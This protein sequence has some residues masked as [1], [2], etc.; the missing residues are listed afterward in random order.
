MKYALSPGPSLPDPSMYLAYGGPQCLVSSPFVGCSI[1][2]TSALICM[3][4]RP[5]DGAGKINAPEISKY[6][7]A[8][9][10]SRFS[11][12]SRILS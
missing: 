12:V 4:N 8:I 3:R 10:L 6:L 7:C 1:F 5:S 9:R 11:K 2:M